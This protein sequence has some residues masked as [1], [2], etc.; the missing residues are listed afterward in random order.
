MF[1]DH[2]D[3][4]AR[5]TF[6]AHGP[7]RAYVIPNGNFDAFEE[8]VG[9]ASEVWNGA[10]GII[11]IATEDG[12]VL[13]CCERH[14]ERRF[15]DEAWLH[16]ALSDGAVRQLNERGGSPLDRSGP[17]EPP[18]ATPAI[19]VVSRTAVS[20]Q[21]SRLSPS[22]SSSPFMHGRASTCALNSSQNGSARLGRVAPSGASTTIVMPRRPLR[23]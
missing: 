5:S 21:P 19:R 17:P 9:F 12:I 2:L 8:C 13:P 20:F 15:L 23:G 22:A 6:Y 10:G 4:L 3:R 18:R 1:D 11:L 16:P 14:I 7:E